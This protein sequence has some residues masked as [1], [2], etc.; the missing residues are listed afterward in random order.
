RAEIPPV[1]DVA[2][3]VKDYKGQAAVAEGE[4]FDPSPANILSR[5][6][7]AEASGLKIT[8]LP[9]KTRGSAV[10]ASLALHFG[11]EKS[12]MNRGTPADFAGAM[13][14]RGTA[15]HSRQQLADEL[16]RLKARA[17]VFG[18][19]GQAVASIE[20]TRENLPDVL[21]LVAEILREPTFPKEEFDQLK[22]E[23]LA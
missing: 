21:R 7:T 10:F 16:D 12:L 20:T 23:E 17:F 13:L 19:A 4:A 8:F 3:L 2:A 1:P 18:G 9:K 15:K 5:T 11:D 14:M 22:Q 6:T